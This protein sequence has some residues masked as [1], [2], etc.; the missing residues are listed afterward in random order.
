MTVARR[1]LLHVPV[2]VGK[3]KT[4]DKFLGGGT[5]LKK[6]K[7][8]ETKKTGNL[9]FPYS[10]YPPRM[11]GEGGKPG[12]R[13]NEGGKVGQPRGEKKRKKKK[14]KNSPVFLFSNFFFFFNGNMFPPKK[15]IFLKK[16]GK[17]RE[18]TTQVFLR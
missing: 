14:E 5:P 13:R 1:N 12:G 11:N 8:L 4:K 18:M 15:L 16:K 6:K 2:E 17:K 7:K 9:S 10:F 3:N